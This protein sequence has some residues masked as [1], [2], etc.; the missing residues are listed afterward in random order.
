L[1]QNHWFKPER[2]TKV[3][4]EPFRPSQPISYTHLPKS[5]LKVDAVTNNNGYWTAL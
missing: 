3:S 5:G 2:C 1:N 4:S